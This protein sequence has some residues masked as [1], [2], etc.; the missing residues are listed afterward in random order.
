MRTGGIYKNYI[1]ALL[2][3]INVFLIVMLL[4]MNYG[5]Y[6]TP[7]IHERDFSKQP[8]VSSEMK[9]VSADSTDVKSE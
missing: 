9:I 6:C 3:V 1:I 5:R 8:D 4:D 7:E 2:V